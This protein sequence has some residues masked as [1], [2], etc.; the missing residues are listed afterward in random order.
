MTH[1]LG[2]CSSTAPQGRV[3]GS[4]GSHSR[5]VLP[6][7]RTQRWCLNEVCGRSA[8]LTRGDSLCQS[9]G[10]RTWART[11]CHVFVIG[12]YSR[13]TESCCDKP[14]TWA[15]SDLP[16]G[17]PLLTLLLAVRL[18][19]VTRVGQLQFLQLD[20]GLPHRGGHFD[21]VLCVDSEILQICL[22][23]PVTGAAFLSCA[24]AHR[25]AVPSAHQHGFVQQN[26]HCS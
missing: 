24:E 4:R 18:S 22:I 14:R 13:A 16:Y 5:T 10:C 11:S 1:S 25:T 17:I 12:L 7:F 8:L 3:G 19:R 6:I 23:S 15:F 20:P 9:P 26:F 21:N 2:S